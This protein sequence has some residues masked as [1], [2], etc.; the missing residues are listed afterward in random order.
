MTVDLRR[1]RIFLRFAEVGNVR[2]AAESLHMSSS[3]VSEQLA[4]VERETGAQLFERHGR[5]LL[6]TPDGHRLVGHARAILD[7]VDEALVD[8]TD[9]QAEPSGTVRVGAFSSAVPSI[10]LP[11]VGA[12]AAAAPRVEVEVVELPPEQAGA[13]L[14]QGTVDL[15]VVS[16]FADSPLPAQPGIEVELLV[17]DPMALVVARTDLLAGR[18]RVP[19]T[20]LAGRRWAFDTA[21]SYLGEVGL[22]ACRQAG[23]E[24]RVVA[25]VSS[26]QILVEHL[27]AGGSVA[28]LPALAARDPRVVS[29][30]TDPPLPDRRISLVTAPPGR[31]RPSALAVSRALRS[32][33]AGIR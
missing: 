5:R 12:L 24:P 6:L 7:R 9:R 4:L 8:L 19:L 21:D 11:A 17:R 10:V 33:A 13:A 32:A 29:V 1:L 23:F 30:P 14:R 27:V 15:A 25:R 16:D 31:R 18:E 20:E 28:F 2:V 22:R 26:Y 3:N